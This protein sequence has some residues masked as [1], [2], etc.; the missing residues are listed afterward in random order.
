MSRSMCE[1]AM[2]TLPH[3]IQSSRYNP[4]YDQQQA[5]LARGH[6]VLG[7][8]AKARLSWLRP[9]KKKRLERQDHVHP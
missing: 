7:I 1:T 3:L 9:T 2:D 6:G 4:G 5:K 8:G